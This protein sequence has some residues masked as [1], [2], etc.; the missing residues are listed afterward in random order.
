MLKAKFEI[1]GMTCS[2]CSAHVDK[3]VNQLNGVRNVSVNLLSNN[4]TLEY[5]EAM[6]TPE[7]I[8]KA[9]ENAGYGA[10]L[11]SDN[12]PKRQTQKRDMNENI[13]MIKKRLIA[14]LIFLFL[15]MY[16]SMHHMLHQW[17]GIPVPNLFHQF[18]EGN[19]NALTFA[20]TQFLLLIPIIYFNRN[21]FITGFKRL[22]KFSPNMDSLI[23]I[24]KWY[25]S[26]IWHI[27]NI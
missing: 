14:S 2:S 19:E 9:V 5:D 17:I 21:Y 3:A 11:C 6:T 22:V 8:I 27:C 24:R 25:W 26:V 10:I 13:T 18:I 23:A 20:F 12:N 15:L 4:M 7:A 16:I 1:Q